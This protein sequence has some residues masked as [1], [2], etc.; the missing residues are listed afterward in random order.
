MDKVLIDYKILW[1]HS[2]IPPDMRIIKIWNYVYAYVYM[3]MS[4]T[5]YI[6]IDKM[7]T[8]Q[9][10]ENYLSAENNVS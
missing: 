3:Y 4:T 10:S 9:H 7:K 6:H 8:N 1:S 5:V 2:R